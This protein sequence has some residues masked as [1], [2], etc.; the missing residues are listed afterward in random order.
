MKRQSDH[1]HS[2]NLDSEEVRGPGVKHEKAHPYS[3]HDDALSDFQAFRDRLYSLCAPAVLYAL[4]S[5]RT[6]HRLAMAF[7]IRWS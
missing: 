4:N 3:D 1:L 2:R 6:I 5:D 7:K